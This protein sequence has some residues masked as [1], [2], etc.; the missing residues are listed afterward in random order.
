METG[1]LRELGMG[2]TWEGSIGTG[3]LMEGPL[4]RKAVVDS[5]H[6]PSAALVGTR[7]LLM[8]H[9]AGVGNS[10]SRLCV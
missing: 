8:H 3:V 7:E 2:E 1:V 9:G 5:S 10:P 6:L 4:S